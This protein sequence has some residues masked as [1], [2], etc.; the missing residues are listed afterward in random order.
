M[1]N[2]I[3]ISTVLLCVVFI[4]ACDIKYTTSFCKTDASVKKSLAEGKTEQD[5]YP[6]CK[7]ESQHC[8]REK[9]YEDGKICFATICKGDSCNR[10]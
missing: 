8:T 6:P 2:A 7:G 3:K 4:S 1:L 10:D 9:Y 5:L